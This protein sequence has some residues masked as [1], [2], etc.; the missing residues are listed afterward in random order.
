M[1]GPSVEEIQAQL[2]V[3]KQAIANAKEKRADRDAKFAASQA[4]S[5][6]FETAATAHAASVEAVIAAEAELQRLN[7][8][9]TPDEA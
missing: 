6:E 5:A 1:P 7:D 4:A 9:H 2:D 3:Y 8:E